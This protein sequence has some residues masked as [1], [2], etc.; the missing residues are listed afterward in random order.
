MI[1]DSLISQYLFTSLITPAQLTGGDYLLY[2]WKKVYAKK[3]KEG[4]IFFVLPL[5][6]I[7]NNIDSAKYSEIN[8]S[9]ITIDDL[10]RDPQIKNII[11]EADEFV[12]KVKAVE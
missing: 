11:S 7:A 9:K 2:G 4:D 8:L 1:S 10:L 3:A 6:V 5:S 12:K